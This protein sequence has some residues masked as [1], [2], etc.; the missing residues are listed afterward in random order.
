ML[1]CYILIAWILCMMD[2]RAICRIIDILCF[3]LCLW[4]YCLKLVGLRSLS[5]F[6]PP[7]NIEDNV[8]FRFGGTFA[9]RN[10]AWFS[11]L[12]VPKFSKFFVILPCLSMLCL[13]RLIFTWYSEELCI[14]ANVRLRLTPCHLGCHWIKCVNLFLLMLS[15]WSNLLEG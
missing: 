2:E 7:M 1:Y 14:F 6:I 12:C 4:D 8:Q 11:K 5:L 15:E 10:D 3:C 9:Q 13:W